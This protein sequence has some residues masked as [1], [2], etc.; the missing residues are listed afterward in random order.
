[1]KEL[2]VRG[3]M[4]SSTA[5]FKHET[6]NKMSAMLKKPGKTAKGGQFPSSKGRRG[7]GVTELVKDVFMSGRKGEDKGRP[8]G[9]V[10]K[11][12][13]MRPQGVF[14]SESA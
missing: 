3:R 13:D 1:L 5:G 7:E 14:D 2:R 9:A 10:R 4:K 6:P 8:K 12:K 11:K